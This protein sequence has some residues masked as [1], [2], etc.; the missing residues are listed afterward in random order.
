MELGVFVV[1]LYSPSDL[2]IVKQTEAA[3]LL[4]KT[5]QS[6]SKTEH[7]RVNMLTVKPLASQKHIT[8]S[9]ASSKIRNNPQPEERVSM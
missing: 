9:A 1:K 7:K 4:P 5:W 8:A 2:M 3:V 6:D